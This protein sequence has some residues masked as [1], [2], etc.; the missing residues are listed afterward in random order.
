MDVTLPITR[1]FAGEHVIG[2]DPPLLPSLPDVWRRRINAFAGRALS[3]KAMSAEQ[4]LRSGM[5]RLYGLSRGPGIAEGLAVSAAPGALGAA[6]AAAFVQIGPGIGIAQ[7]GED[8]QVG[9]NLRVALGDIPVILRVDLADMLAGGAAPT[10]GVA[11]VAPIAA[12]TSAA[13]MAQRLRPE[14]PRR[15]GD[16][17][18]T[19]AAN[20]ASGAL[21]HVAVLVAQPIAAEILGRPLDQCPPDPRDD[22]YI[23][24]QR[25]DG[26]EL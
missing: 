3:D 8:I 11:P 1:S 7:N 5:Q 13:P 6:P 25:I 16:P 23:D 26:M 17:L 24:L 2:I 12:D 20:P 14:A 4:A 22:P 21:A 10:P 9:R 18:A 15:L 19:I